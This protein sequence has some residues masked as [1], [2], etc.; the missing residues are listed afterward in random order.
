MVGPLIPTYNRIEPVDVGGMERLFCPLSPDRSE[1]RSAR[2]RTNPIGSLAP[3][4]AVLPQSGVEAVDQSFSGEGLRQ[5]TGCSRLQS[6]LA[7]ALDRES[8]D[9]NERHPVS[10][11][12][13]VGLQLETAHR[14]HLDVCYHAPGVI[15]VRR[16]QEL[17]GRCECMNDVSKRPHEIVGRGANGA[18]IVND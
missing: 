3:T 17:L 4:I 1:T 14:W 8:R 9:E 6:S 5:K 7:S 12:E 13:Q 18:V 10:L 2:C 11:G 15:Q 16:P